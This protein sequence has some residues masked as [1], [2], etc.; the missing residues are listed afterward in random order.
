[1]RM[2]RKKAAPTMAKRTV[3]HDELAVLCKARDTLCNYCEADK[4]E[5]CIVTNL[6]DDAYSEL[7]DDEPSD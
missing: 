1:M 2:T 7:E 5:K 4:C 3:T 6:I